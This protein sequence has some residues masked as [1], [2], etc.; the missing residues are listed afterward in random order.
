LRKLRKFAG[1]LAARARRT[2]LLSAAYLWRRAMFR[3]RFI[4]VTGSVGKTTTKDLIAATLSEFPSQ[5]ICNFGSEN[6]TQEV[7][8]TLL[9]VRPRHR[10]AVIEAATSRPGQ[11]AAVA[12]LVAPDIAVVLAVARTHTNTFAT[13]EDTAAEKASLLKFVGPNGVAI[14][15]LDDP[16]VAAM[17]PPPG[18]RTIH[19]GSTAGAGVCA[20]DVK[21]TYPDGL[22]C[23][24]ASSTETALV[25][26]QLVGAHWLPSVLATVAVALECGMPLDRIA[27]RIPRIPPTTGR[28]DPQI[29]PSGAVILRDDFNGSLDTYN[30][31]FETLRHASATRKILVITTLGDTPESW[32]KRLRRVAEQ[33]AGVVDLLILIG[34]RDDT[35]RAA[36]AALRA[37]MSAEAVRMCADTRAAADLLR[38]ELRPGDLALLRGR[39]EHHVARVA[40][41]LA[42]PQGLNREV[43]CW[44]TTCSKRILCDHCPEL[45]AP[46]P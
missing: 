42:D 35:K 31:A 2:A 7:A 21:A 19:F 37:G 29:L 20:S 34:E 4:A 3:T 24:I 14:L 8:H 1:E 6:T 27:A 18:I 10:F 22:S 41:D 40:L 33:S 28:M 5:T 12:R 39:I 36:K 45:W 38:T 32:D 46:K 30:A 25:R 44:K 17:Q 23:T 13:L 9:R 16:R 43:A 11:L 26:S 15:N